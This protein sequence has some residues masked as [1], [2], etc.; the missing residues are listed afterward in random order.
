MRSLQMKTASVI[1]LKEICDWVRIAWMRTEIVKILVCIRTS[2]AG[3]FVVRQFTRLWAG[4]NVTHG[5]VVLPRGGL[6]VH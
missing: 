4:R 5:M 6:D 2:P 3:I 1:W